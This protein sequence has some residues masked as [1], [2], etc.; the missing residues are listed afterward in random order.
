MEGTRDNP[1]ASG[2]LRFGR[3]GSVARAVGPL[4]IWVGPRTLSGQFAFRGDEQRAGHR[5]LAGRVTAVSVDEALAGTRC[6]G[7]DRDVVLL[8]PEAL[9]GPTLQR[10]RG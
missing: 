3:A 1:R 8:L 9:D 7:G 2:V 4:P 10:L 5:E 6:Y